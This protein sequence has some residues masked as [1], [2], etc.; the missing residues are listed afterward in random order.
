MKTLNINISESDFIKYN[1]Q[2]EAL[3]FD[4]L[5]VKI[6]AQLIPATSKKSKFEDTPAFNLWQ[7]RE[8]MAD[9]GQYVDELRKPR[10]QNVC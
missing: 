10:Q 1:L 5:V 9:V 8:D 6:K 4:E 3:T 2:H 7:N